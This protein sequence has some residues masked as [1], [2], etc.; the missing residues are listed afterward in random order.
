MTLK[1]AIAKVWIRSHEPGAE[2]LLSTLDLSDDDLGAI[3]SFIEAR[4]RVRERF[5]PLT[6]AEEAHFELEYLSIC[7]EIGMAY[8][9][10]ML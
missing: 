3:G 9:K 4:K 7:L 8:Q 2:I 10:G 6:E 5:N 1:E